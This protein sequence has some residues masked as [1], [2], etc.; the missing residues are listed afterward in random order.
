MVRRGRLAAISISAALLLGSSVLWAGA[1]PA[2]CQGG[3]APPGEPPAGGPPPG[4]IAF[5]MHAGSPDDEFFGAGPRPPF[6]LGLDLTEAQ[7]DKIFDIVHAAAPALRNQSKALRKARASLREL[8]HSAQ[9][10]ASRAK[11]LAE[12]VGGA[13]SQLELLQVRLD[14]DLFSVLTS[15]QQGKVLQRERDLAQRTRPTWGEP[16]EPCGPGRGPGPAH[17][18]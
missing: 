7:Q 3:P 17:R 11:A 13:Q 5:R 4:A 15:E 18:P 6:L 10:D 14:H 8:A 16:G 2:E 9:F 12:A 1:P